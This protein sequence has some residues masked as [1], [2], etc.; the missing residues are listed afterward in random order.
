MTWDELTAEYDIAPAIIERAMK[1][2]AKAIFWM[3]SRPNL[4]LYRHTV[5]VD[6]KLEKMPQA[7]VAREDAERMA[8]FLNGGQASARSFRNAE[9]D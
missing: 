4:L 9:P 2:G 3:S 7:V 5:T 1:A 8:R 6:G